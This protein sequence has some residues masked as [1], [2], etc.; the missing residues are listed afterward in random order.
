MC[1]CV[2]VT[3]AVNLVVV[4]HIHCRMKYA[5]EKFVG[6]KVGMRDMCFSQYVFFYA[7]IHLFLSILMDTTM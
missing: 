5:G 4:L 2:C 3:G 6:W 7:Y 1:V